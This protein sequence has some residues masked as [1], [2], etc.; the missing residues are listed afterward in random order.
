[1]FPNGKTTWYIYLTCLTKHNPNVNI[2]DFL[3]YYGKK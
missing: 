2:F 3:I 1:M